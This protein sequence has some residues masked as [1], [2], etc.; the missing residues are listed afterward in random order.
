VSLTSL[1][2]RVQ[3]SHALHQH[4]HKL[5]ARGG[6][7]CAGQSCRLA[8]ATTCVDTAK[9]FMHMCLQAQVSQMIAAWG[10]DGVMAL[11]GEQCGSNSCC[12][13]GNQDSLINNHRQG[14]VQQQRH[15]VRYGGGEDW[16]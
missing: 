10:V 12:S 1:L 16:Q 8:E 9:W 3:S 14:G 4:T 6:V 15:G 13:S 5:R 11:G 2:Q 7:P